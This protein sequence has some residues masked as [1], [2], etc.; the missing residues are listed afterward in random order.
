MNVEQESRV[1]EE[2]EVVGI[3]PKCGGDI[4]RK[5]VCGANTSCAG[6]GYGTASWPCDC[7]PVEGEEKVSVV[8]PSAYV[9][10]SSE[11]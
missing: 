2:E 7:S 1:V 4:H 9:T 8:Y 6:C 11:G 5:C 10:D 3:C